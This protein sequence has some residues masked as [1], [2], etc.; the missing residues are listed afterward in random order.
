[1]FKNDIK[2]DEYNENNIKMT[3]EYNAQL[4]ND[5]YQMINDN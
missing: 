5:Y 2:P 1:M 3:T 4:L